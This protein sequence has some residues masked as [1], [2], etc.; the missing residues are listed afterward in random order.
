MFFLFYAV[1]ILIINTSMNICTSYSI[2]ST[3]SYKLVPGTAI[4]WF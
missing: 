3:D 1:R 4:T 2:Q